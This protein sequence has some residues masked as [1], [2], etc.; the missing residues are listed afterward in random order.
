MWTTTANSLLQKEIQITFYVAFKYD[1]LLVFY[2]CY[3]GHVKNFN[4]I[5]PI[6][7]CP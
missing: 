7:H 1:L 6:K 5:K 4:D 2:H 3:F